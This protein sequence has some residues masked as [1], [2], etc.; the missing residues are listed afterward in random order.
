MQHKMQQA[1]SDHFFHMKNMNYFI[2]F[3]KLE[4]LKIPNAGSNPVRVTK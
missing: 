4:L 2:F 3:V 1:K